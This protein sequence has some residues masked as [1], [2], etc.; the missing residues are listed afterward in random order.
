LYPWGRAWVVSSI[1]VLALVAAFGAS[2]AGGGSGGIWS[3]SGPPVEATPGNGRVLQQITSVVVTHSNETTSPWRWTVVATKIVVVLPLLVAWRQFDIMWLEFLLYLGSGVTSVFNHLGWS[4]QLDPLGIVRDSWHRLDVFFAYTAIVA[5]LVWLA[6]SLSDHRR[7][8]VTL[9][10]AFL[11]G[12][13]CAFDAPIE[14]RNLP[15]LG[16]PLGILYLATMCTLR[17]NRNLSRRGLLA[18]VVFA[19]GAV[20]WF[21]LGDT[22]R[23]HYILYHDLSHVFIYLSLYAF[24]A[25]RREEDA[26]GDLLGLLPTM[27]RRRGRGERAERSYRE[28]TGEVAYSL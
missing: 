4:Y 20:T 2:A 8:A 11:I 1:A 14:M 24:V 25:C 19:I 23:E 6:F 9:P 16:L 18:T 5:T 12:I 22:E 7:V 3:I 27:S 17:F 13:S 28:P 15:V 21:I 10:L 26:G